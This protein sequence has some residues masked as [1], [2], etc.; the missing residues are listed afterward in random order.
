MAQVL[1]AVEAVS[2][3]FET[4]KQLLF[5]P[6]RFRKWARLAIIT[7]LSGELGSGGN[8]GGNYNIPAPSK[9]NKDFVTHFA[10]AQPWDWLMQNLVWVA[11]ILAAAVGLALVLMYVHSVFRFLLFD[12]VVF[13]RYELGEGWR[14][15]QTQGTSFFY[16]QL[17]LGLT[18]M[19]VL[20]LVVGVPVYLAWRAGVFQNPSEHL[21]LLFGGGILLFFVLVGIVI[22]GA[23]IALFARDFVVPHMALENIGVLEGWRRLRPML[24]AQKW[25]YA[26][27][28]GMK[29]LLALAAAIVFAILN[30]AALLLLLIPLI[31]AGVIVG[32]AAAAAGL[33][34]NVATITAA[35]IAGLGVIG[36]LLYVMGFV[37]T[38]SAIFFQSYTLYFFS[39]RYPAL[40][41]RL[42]PAPP[43][44]PPPMPAPQPAA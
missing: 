25:S 7:L 44:A 26:G 16:W 29:I 28:V 20:G 40:A 38:P 9:S 22:A 12:A 5:Q 14:R 1:N 36:L 21:A 11:I 39:G 30:V 10:A 33:T 19:V 4:T 42:H 43:P 23:L 24:A 8:L 37:T 27:Y 31:I 32:F 2:P 6:F 34:W 3:A 41:E 15:W 35:V 18:M 13:D 17:C